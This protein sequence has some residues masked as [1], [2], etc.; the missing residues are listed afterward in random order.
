MSIKGEIMKKIS[1][2]IIRDRFIIVAIFIILT[3][4][5]FTLMDN[6]NTNYDNS[7]YLPENSLATKDTNTIR[8]A[9]DFPI[10]L[11][12]MVS[13]IEKTEISSIKEKL[14]AISDVEFVIIDSESETN[15]KEGHALFTVFLKSNTDNIGDVVQK[16]ELSLSDYEIN[17]SG[18]SVNT[19]H[20]EQKVLQ[21][22]PI[23]LIVACVVILIILLISTQRY[24]EPLAFGLVI[25]I[26]IIINMGTNVMFS[27]VSYVTKSVAAVLQLGL[28]MDYSIILINNYYREK[29]KESNS[30]K[31]MITAL[32]NSFKPIT[33]SSLTT[34]IGLV[35]LLF[36]SF[37]IGKDIGLVLA[38][39]IMI[40]LISVFVLLPNVILWFEKIP[41]NKKH[42]KINISS[43]SVKSSS[44]KISGAITAFAIIFIGAMFLVQGQNSY[45]F[46]D[47]TKFEDEEAIKEVFGDSNTF[48]I[49]IPNNEDVYKNETII[50]NKL[51]E[52]YQNS[53]ISY[54]GE[55]NSTKKQ[56]SYQNLLELTS[57]S[58][59]KQML[60]VYALDNDFDYKITYL[61]Y[62]SELETLIQNNAIEP[63]NDMSSLLKVIQIK[64]MMDK[65][66]TSQELL[67]SG[68]LPTETD[69]DM[70]NIVFNTYA[71][72]NGY[73]LSDTLTLNQFISTLLYV[74]STN[75]TLISDNEILSSIQTLQEKLNMIDN[76]LM[77]MVST[78]EF[79]GLA[80][81]NFGVT[82]DA[83]QVDNLFN[84]YFAANSLEPKEKVQTRNLLAF[85]V[86]NQLLPAE[87][88]QMI[89]SILTAHELSNTPATT[90]EV[91][92]HLN[93][94]VLLLTG[95]YGS[96]NID[97][98]L[99]ELNYVFALD[100]VG[101]IQ[102]VTLN[103]TSFLTQIDLLCSNSKVNML[104]NAELITNIDLL[105]GQI[106]LLK[107]PQSLSKSNLL[108]ML[109]S[110]EN[111]KLELLSK[112]IFASSLSKTSLIDDYTVTIEDLLVYTTTE[113]LGLSETDLKQLNHTKSQLDTMQSI[114][115]SDDISLIVLNTTLPYE[116][117][118]TRD[119]I[120]YVYHDV[121]DLVD[122]DAYFIGYSV[123]DA[124]IKGYF[125][126]DLLKIN[127]ITIGAVLF[128][129]I[130]TF[131][132]I[133]IPI[134]LVTT[135]EGAI[136]TTLSF[137][138]LINEK[139]FFMCYII[140]G[141]IQLGATIDYAIILTSNY[142][143][144]RID[145][146][147]VIA[148]RRALR[149]SI[150]SILTSGAI[151][152]IAGFAIAI[153]STQE[154]IVSIGSFL[155]RGTIVSMLF[156][157]TILPSML[158]TFD[159]LIIKKKKIFKIK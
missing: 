90:S 68:L 74:A 110:T 85:I 126:D 106:Q 81:N 80:L 150:P 101:A 102:D 148:L 99:I 155:G 139:I 53:I 97:D 78:E 2:W 10:S 95:T 17:L 51:D 34:V 88:L 129:L 149:T 36:M 117:Q 154:S 50:M 29:E 32:S 153:V 115:S 157:V 82:L 127:L 66:F 37:T 132:S 156:V 147:A 137:S 22:T 46:T 48:V 128:I 65:D 42:K 21:E 105:K 69:I 57:E 15:Y 118:E 43:L 71:F 133:I 35:A 121:F 108:A 16:I 111:A 151:L 152:T 59:A 92:D 3:V 49:G 8:D 67:D 20:Q 114:I 13:N 58:K 123:S 47:E 138:Y 142:Q 64:Q 89:G 94:L 125:E 93:T 75:E 52:K 7:K 19:Y 62:I 158:F 1:K 39:G 28:S 87:Q 100:Q 136:W 55:I 23:I 79:Q 135:I 103:F 91:N 27:E 122:D 134:L 104:I 124:E 40:S 98:M 107:Q 83:T 131:K 61:E 12:L 41:L 18:N 4:L 63:T 5:T 70:L 38:K 86:E 159:K 84:S 33:S 144:Y 116:S 31:A 96:V 6:V 30:K 145:N 130:I 11:S 26:A 14:D 112:A 109:S 76:L 143:K 9:I 77:S 54:L 73:T 72:E 44:K 60:S 56:V 140:I 119:F 141:A 25:G 24:L 146:D 45:V 120:E 113:D